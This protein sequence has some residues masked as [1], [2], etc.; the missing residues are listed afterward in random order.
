MQQIARFITELFIG[1]P[2]DF[3]GTLTVTSP[4]A[5]S[6]VGLRFRGAN[7]STIPITNVS[8]GGAV[9]TISEGV[10]G[11]LAVLLPQFAAGGG[12]TTEVVLV[13]T[14]TTSITARVDLFKADGTR[15]METRARIAGGWF[16]FRM[17]I[18]KSY[19]AAPASFQ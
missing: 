17:S 7:F 1:L 16:R 2:A 9:P 14:A 12:W 5:V 6:I 11:A 19:G 15:R 10:G 3:L 4:S 18:N 13:N 8:P